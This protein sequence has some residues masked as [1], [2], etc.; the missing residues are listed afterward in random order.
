LPL[1]PADL[2]TFLDQGR[3]DL[4]EDPALDPPLEPV[5]DGALGAVP[6]GELVPLAA[7]PHPEED[8]V[9]HRPPMGDMAAGG[10]LGPE[11]LEDRLDPPPEFVGDLPDR[12]QRLATGFS[13]SHGSAPEVRL[14]EGRIRYNLLH[15]RGVPHVVG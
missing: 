3:P 14:R 9:E 12:I 2:V 5:V 8:G 6:L 10:F 13:A 1:H 7:A 15:A 11:L 4:L